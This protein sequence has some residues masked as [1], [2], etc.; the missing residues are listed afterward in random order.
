MKFHIFLAAFLFSISG[1]LSSGQPIVVVSHERELNVLRSPNVII[2]NMDDMGYGD[3]VCYGGSPYKTDNIDALAVSGI[4][5]T[6][7]YSAQ[8]VCSASRAGLLTGCYPTRVGISGALFP[9]SRIALNPEEE[10]IAEL[11]KKK[12][13]ATGMVGKWHLGQTEPFLPP[14]QGF[15]E[16]F[17]LPY[18]NDMWPVGYDGKP[19]TD[20]TV[21]AYRFPPLPLIDGNAVIGYIRNHEDQSTLT[22]RYTDKAV[23]FINRHKNKPFFLYIAHS[24]VHVPIAASPDFRGKSRA[25][26]F[27]DVMEEVDWS[28]GKIMQA[29]RENKLLENTMVVFTS[30]NGP[31]LIFGNHAGNTSGLR[32]G[33]GTAWDGGLKVPCIISWKGKINGGKVNNNLL[34]Q[35][36]LLPTIA[37]YC[38]A[39]L[40]K[41]K[42][43][44]ISFRKLLDGNDTVVTRHELVYYYDF[45]NLKAIRKDG[46]KLSFPCTSQTYNS[47]ATIGADGFPGKY[48]S[49]KVEAGLYNLYT[50]PG[51]DRNLISVYPEIATELGLIAD[52][53][54]K[55]L[56]D[57]L[58]GQK[59]NEVRSPASVDFKK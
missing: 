23:G 10:T 49:V 55:T 52:K 21:F 46:W 56:G 54:R 57:G 24:M 48:G 26:L 47:P 15:D 14:G 58:T 8:A 20:S 30:D 28:V 19:V 36:D 41:K 35:I 5:F 22:R 34:S 53:Y 11:L 27:G 13:Y 39:D 31:W 9:D 44:G 37:D 7:F 1:K 45:N 33:K 3:P 12:G 43:D 42:I 38:G 2:I 18:S 16:Y 4:R 32:E 40:P 50:D 51:E 29:L 6:N 17:G 59:G 25:G